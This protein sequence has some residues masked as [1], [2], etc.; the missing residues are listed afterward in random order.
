MRCRIIQAEDSVSIQFPG[1]TVKAPGY[2]EPALR[3]IANAKE[4]SVRAIPDILTEG[5][6]M[7]LVRRLIREG[8]LTVA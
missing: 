4:F 7:L 5:S 6:K 1:N 8:L 3:F 2:T